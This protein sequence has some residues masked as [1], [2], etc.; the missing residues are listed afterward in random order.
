MNQNLAIAIDKNLNKYLSKKIDI[1]KYKDLYI[2]KNNIDVLNSFIKIFNDY[3]LSY[4]PRSK[5]TSVSS[6]YLLNKLERSKKFQK[7]YFNIL[8]ILKEI[9]KIKFKI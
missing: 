1:S 9:K 7:N 2:F 5:T 4:A 8:I 3:D 6:Q